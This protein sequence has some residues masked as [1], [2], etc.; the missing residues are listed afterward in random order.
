MKGYPMNERAI[1]VE[2]I[3]LTDRRALALAI[4]AVLPF[5]STDQTRIHLASVSIGIRNGR[6]I[7]CATDGH[8][9]A[10][11]QSKNTDAAMFGFYG[12]RDG[13][14]ANRFGT[15][16]AIVLPAKILATALKASGK[17]AEA[18]FFPHEGPTGSLRIGVTLQSG[19]WQNFTTIPALLGVSYPPIFQVCTSLDPKE[20]RAQIA[21]E[22]IEAAAALGKALGAKG[23]EITISDPLAPIVFSME[24]D[25]FIGAIWQMPMRLDHGKNALGR[26]Q[27]INQIIDPGPAH[28]RAPG[29]P[30]LA[31]E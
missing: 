11:V 1:E 13:I 30:A 8:R 14:E 2:K 18:V 15:H 19:E 4:K 6:L 29:G 10:L 17:T 9:A 5:A 16:N 27:R 3:I 7:V 25:A 31:A 21:P 22:Y 26:D 24:S 23:V 28:M 20:N 12:G